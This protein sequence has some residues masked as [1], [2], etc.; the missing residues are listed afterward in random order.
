MNRTMKRIAVLFLSLTMLLCF[1]LSAQAAKPSTKNVT[2]KVT[3]VTYVNENLKTYYTVKFTNKSSYPVKSVKVKFTGEV[4]EKVE[5]TKKIKV[6]LK[7]G[8]SR[9][10]KIYIDK[11]VDK[12][13]QVKAKIKDIKY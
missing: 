3:K 12:P 9:T 5:C 2:A 1:A 13:Y 8:K 4:S 6:N 10:M 7:P 11:Y